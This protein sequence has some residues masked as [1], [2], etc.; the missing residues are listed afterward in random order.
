MFKRTSSFY[1][2]YI[3]EGPQASSSLLSVPSRIMI[4]VA[5][6]VVVLSTCIVDIGHWW[7][8]WGWLF[9]DP[10]IRY[11]S[12]LR[13]FMLNQCIW[14]SRFVMRCTPI[15]TY[16]LAT[17]HRWW[18]WES[19]CIDPHTSYAS[20]LGL[21]NVDS[22]RRCF[23]SMHMDVEV[24]DNVTQM[25]S[26][27]LTFRSSHLIFIWASPTFVGFLTSAPT[28]SCALRKLALQDL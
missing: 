6:S 7:Y 21:L 18:T 14:M 13:C 2:P 25:G 24:C 23:E 28:I 27:R 1:P 4:D 10:H 22:L 16:L 17:R 11:A 3:G 8:T 9:S 5:L 12:Y 26:E 19:L 20:Y 15:S